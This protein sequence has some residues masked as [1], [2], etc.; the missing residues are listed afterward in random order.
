MVSIVTS[1]TQRDRSLISQ[2]CAVYL[3][4]RLGS[5]T[6]NR[7]LSIHFPVAVVVAARMLLT[8]DMTM[9]EQNSSAAVADDRGLDRIQERQVRGRIHRGLG[10]GAVAA[11]VAIAS[12]GV[13]R[14]MGMRLQHGVEHI[15]AFDQVAAPATVAGIDVGTRTVSDRPRRS[16]SIN[17]GCVS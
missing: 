12:P 4:F 13:E 15:A 3:S 1:G 14:T 17:S 8:S 6:R 16:L 10:S 11:P 7:L 2:S 5:V 9:F